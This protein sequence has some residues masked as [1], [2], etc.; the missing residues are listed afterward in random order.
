M[1]EAKPS[2]DPWKA[3]VPAYLDLSAKK[4]MKKRNSSRTPT[5]PLLKVLPMK[6]LAVV[7]ERPGKFYPSNRTFLY[8]SL[9]AISV[10]ADKRTDSSLLA[11]A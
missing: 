8:S 6:Q 9:D 2:F 5:C 4:S 11:A 7:P 1:S 3:K 10:P